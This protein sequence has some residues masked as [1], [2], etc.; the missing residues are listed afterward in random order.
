M[1]RFVCK[2]DDVDFCSLSTTAISRSCIARRSPIRTRRNHGREQDD[3]LT[4]DFSNPFSLP[5][6]YGRFCACLPDRQLRATD[7]WITLSDVRRRWVH[8]S[9]KSR[10]RNITFRTPAESL[11]VDAGDG[12]RHHRCHSVDSTFAGSLN[13]LE[14]PG[15]TL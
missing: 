12:G 13:L 9:G 14:G 1:R 5:S 6:L 8:D 2:V 15:P 10:L 11:T 4:I 7:D 3:K